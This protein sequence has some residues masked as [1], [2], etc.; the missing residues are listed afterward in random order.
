MSSPPSRRRP[1]RPAGSPP[2]REAILGAARHEFG[3]HGYDA[4]TIRAIARRAGVDAAL[5]HHYFGTKD[6]L[7][8]AAHAL[9]VQPSDDLPALLAG[10]PDELGERVVRF[11]LTHLAADGAGGPGPVVG[12]LRGALTQESAAAMLREFVSAEVLAPV[13]DH[14]KLPDPQLRASLV[15]SQL[16]GIAVA[17]HVV[18]VEALVTADDE[19][20]VAWYGPT[21]QRYLTAASPIEAF[22]SPDS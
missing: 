16:M 3:E 15:L 10:P 6:G 2:T 12:L 20:L 19:R 4:A 1:G 17:R 14:L 18:G 7:F 22:P 13:I 8:A 5:V 9:P 11:F 21:V